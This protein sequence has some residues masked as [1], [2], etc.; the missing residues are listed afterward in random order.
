M[1]ITVVIPCRNEVLYIEDCI[2][3]IYNCDLPAEANIEVFVVDGMSDDGTRDKVEV[4]S[5]RYPSLGIVDNVKQLTPFAFN[6]GIYAG[7]N[8]DFIQI[9]GARHILSA[10][11]IL[12]CFTKL[13]ADST[14]WCVGGKIENEYINEVGEV[15][16]RAMGTTFGMGLGNFRTLEKSGFT[17]TVTSPMYPY[18]VF[19]KIGFFDEELIRNQDDDFNFRVTSEGGKIFYDNDI[20][21]K[22]YVRGNF[23][24]LWRQFFQ[25]G[26]WKVYVNKKHKA[27]TTLRQLVPPA[28]ALYLTLLIPVFFIGETLFLLSLIPLVGYIIL[29]IVFSLKAM[30]STRKFFHTLA[31]F[32]LLHIS[33]GLG[34]LKGLVEFILL[35]KKP[36]ESQKRLSR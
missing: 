27:I 9:V 30:P 34:Y 20:S 19:E 25:Y 21:L 35:N 24:G 18:W 11:Y 33:Y 2:H 28:F 7:Q 15:I 31:T 22:Y 17:D 14:T 8:T 1:K 3:A 16:S 36:S 23:K 12:N 26:Y 13:Q 10:N 5:S 4:M 32:P 29:N 6:L